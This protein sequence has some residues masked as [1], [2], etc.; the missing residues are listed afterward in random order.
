MPQ[1]I[2]TL[3]GIFPSFFPL[4]KLLGGDYGSIIP[5]MA[6]PNPCN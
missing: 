2:H 4:W 6:E 5:Q 1:R 3:V